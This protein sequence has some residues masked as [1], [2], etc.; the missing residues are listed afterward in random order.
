MKIEKVY[1][2]DKTPLSNSDF[3]SLYTLAE[4][5]D[6]CDENELQSAYLLIKNSN[7]NF[8]FRNNKYN[9]TSSRYTNCNWY[10]F[11]GLPIYTAVR[12]FRI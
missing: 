10:R 11:Y 3:N 7:F 12:N 1:S 2:S 5:E 4:L 8:S 6:D 9:L